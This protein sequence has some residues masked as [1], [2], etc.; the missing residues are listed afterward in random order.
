MVLHLLPCHNPVLVVPFESQGIP[1]IRAFKS[2]LSY[3]GKVHFVACKKIHH[4][5]RLKDI[6]LKDIQERDVIFSVRV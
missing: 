2:D 5:I 4:S 1:G 3:S 6:R